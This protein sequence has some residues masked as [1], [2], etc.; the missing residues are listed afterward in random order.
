MPYEIPFSQL[1]GLGEEDYP[2]FPAQVCPNE[3]PD[4][5]KHCSLC[6][7][8]LK[9]NPEMYQ[10]LKDRQTATGVSLARCIK[11]GIDNRGHPCLKS[12]GAVAGDAECYQVFSPLFEKLIEGRHGK[13]PAAHMKCPGRRTLTAESAEPLEGYVISCKVAASRNLDGTPFPPAASRDQRQEVEHMISG[14][15]LQMEGAL[16]GTYFPLVGS[17]SY[18]S[19]PD[20]MTLEEEK[21]LTDDHL[22]FQHPDAPAVLSTGSGRHWPHGRGVFVNERKTMTLWINEEE[23]L[24]ATS[25]RQGGDVQAAFRELSAV[26]AHISGSLADRAGFAKSD[27][28]GYLTSNPA[29]IGTALRVSVIVK[30]PLLKQKKEELLQW[31]SARRLVGKGAISESGDRMPDLVEVSSRD[32]IDITEEETVNMLVE[33]VAQLVRAE[34]LMELGTSAAE[35]LAQQPSLIES[36]AASGA[37]AAGDLTPI[38]V[39]DVG[40]GSWDAAGS[41]LQDMISNAVV[42]SCTALGDATNEAAGSSP[43]AERALL[44]LKQRLAGSIIVAAHSGQLDQA[45]KVLA[46]DAAA[47]KIQALQRGKSARTLV[48]QEKA[49]KVEAVQHGKKT[50]E[51]LQVEGSNDPAA[52]EVPPQETTGTGPAVAAQQE[53]HEFLR[54][55]LAGLLSTAAQDGSLQEALAG[56]NPTDEPEE[57]TPKPPEMPED[58]KDILRAQLESSLVRGGLQQALAAE[59]TDFEEVRLQLQSSMLQ[60]MFDGSLEGALKTAFA[61][62]VADEDA[63][64]IVAEQPDMSGDVATLADADEEAFELEKLKERIAQKMLAASLDGSLQAALDAFQRPKKNVDEIRSKLADQLLDSLNNGSLEKALAPLAKD[65][66]ELKP[67]AAAPS[68]PSGP[69]GCDEDLRQ[70]I[71]S[72]LEDAL[73]D[74]SL[75]SALQACIAPKQDLQPKQPPEEPVDIEMLRQKLAH[76]FEV[77]VADGSLEVVLAEQSKAVAAAASEDLREKVGAQM[78]AAFNDGSLEAALAEANAEAEETDSERLRSKLATSLSQSFLDGSLEMA[79]SASLPEID[80]SNLQVAKPARQSRPPSAQAMS[81]AVGLLHVLSSYDRRIGK[82]AASIEAAEHAIRDRIQQTEMLQVQLTAARGDLRSLNEIWEKQQ[83]A[84]NAEEVRDLML[85]EERQRAADSLELE[86]LKHKHAAVDMEAHLLS[87]RSEM[88]STAASG[89][90]AGC[91][92]QDSPLTSWRSP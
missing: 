55:R 65:K 38:D 26:L 12:I 71:A 47:K 19:K 84:I 37:R 51:D 49:E 28:L 35:A 29:N 63:V 90:E 62:H 16:K 81:S 7:D 80:S 76:R 4:L 1:P 45:A 56:A 46:E 64:T 6:A 52:K 50:R 3:L 79:L 92:R 78:L 85:Q 83:A 72:Q 91:S 74:G 22:L 68:G 69:S 82:I 34:R 73:T 48:Q 75:E 10:E 20:G 60:A 67:A 77:S 9:D 53:Y 42:T 54:Q 58:E 24:K 32:R 87:N 13:V 66:D 41:T 8:V 30:L 17:S 23:H 88:A 43:D 14:A 5:S 70:R 86:K 11:T 36:P 21:M 31:C 57:A 59:E 61:D 44:E 39:P 40:S 2:G 25:Q 33:G 15:A 89:Q 18:P 27:R